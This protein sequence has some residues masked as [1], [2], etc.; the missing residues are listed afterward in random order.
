MEKL[1]CWRP[2]L[3]AS[4]P[5]LSNL[6]LRP[7]EPA[8]HAPI[9]SW[10][11]AEG[12]PG[13]HKHEPLRADGLPVLLALPG[14]HSH[15]LAEAGHPPCGFGQVWINSAGTVNLVRIIVAPAARG[16]GLGALLSRRL[17]QQAWRLAPGRPVKLRVY[18]SNHAALKVYRGLGFEE[19]ADESNAE[20]LAMALAPERQLVPLTRA[21]TEGWTRSRGHAAPVAEPDWLRV[22][23]GL[24]EQIRRYV[25]TGFDAALIER[26]A[27]EQGDRPAV[28]LKIC[29]ERAQVLPLLD[30]R[31]LP[32][33]PEALM[34]I[35]LAPDVHEVL[36]PPSPFRLERE[37]RAGFIALRLLTLE[38]ELA[39]SGQV[40]LFE[41]YA[42]FDR[43]VTAE[44]HRRLGL[45]RWVMRA[46][47]QAAIA[48][49]AAWGVLVATEQ[50]VALYR[51]LGWALA[52]PMVAAATR[53]AP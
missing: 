17:L 37:E 21:W 12:W 42:C 8:D 31:W 40:A 20:V 14:H 10:A 39:A 23:V 53:M 44:T 51:A 19:L 4:S 1:L 32:H 6:L 38:G 41:R 50:G 35:A 24:P 34:S 46:L 13:L 27:G 11:M 49:G 36:E 48:Q 5:P 18:R 47:S 15:V 16:R 43:I 28:W 45:G 9:A 30:G 26:L 22:E 52:S 2:I 29:A 25:L 33:A 7:I 3:F